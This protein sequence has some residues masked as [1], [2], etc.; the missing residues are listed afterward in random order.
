MQFGQRYTALG[1]ALCGGMGAV[2]PCKD[3]VL[4]RKVAVKIIQGDVEERRMLDE[5]QALLKLRSKHV[6]QIYDL[7]KL[8][9]GAI[10][11]VQEFIEG[12]DL[13]DNSTRATTPDQLYKQLWQ[14]ASG[15][16]D[17]HLAG[18]IHRDVKPNNMKLD[19]EGVIKLFDF[20]LAR[21]DG[22]SAATMG[23]VGTHGFAAPELYGNEIYFTPAIDVY[24]F[25]ATAL[26][27]AARYLPDELT[28]SPPKPISSEFIEHACGT[29][30]PDVKSAITQCLRTCAEERPDMK[31]I[32]TILARRLLANRHQGLLVYQGQPSYL[33]TNNRTVSASL[34]GMGGLQVH[35]DGFDFVVSEI[36]GDVYINNKSAQRGQLLPGS[37]VI[38]LGAPD[39]GNRRRYITFDLSSPEVVL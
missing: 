5:I 31:S 21:E 26:Y 38:A 23:F 34:P 4:E 20:G 13:L 8:H 37:C 15:I 25:G 16:D 7:L 6:V 32:R 3:E 24:A 17:I 14:I 22:P 19:P 36:E 35:Y 2:Y 1:H 12:P 9:D 29:L 10:A 28:A 11:I 33:N 39:Q 27:L 18:V 30:A